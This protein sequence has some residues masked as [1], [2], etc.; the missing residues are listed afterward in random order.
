MAKEIVIHIDI[1]EF[2]RGMKIRQKWEPSL[3]TLSN[4]I[5]VLI[6]SITTSPTGCLERDIL[7]AATRCCERLERMVEEQK[8]AESKGVGSQPHSQLFTALSGTLGKFGEP[9]TLS[10]ADV[11]AA[12]EEV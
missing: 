11:V 8:A 12:A 7:S 9:L 1:E 2:E 6:N 3:S 5:C 4:M 10:P